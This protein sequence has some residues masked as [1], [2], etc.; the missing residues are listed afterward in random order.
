MLG[1]YLMPNQSQFVA[2][3]AIY[4]IYDRQ[5]LAEQ[6][7]WSRKYQ[8]KA[9]GKKAERWKLA[10]SGGMFGFVIENGIQPVDMQ[11]WKDGK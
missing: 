8:G 7:V 3:Y 2:P 1:Q 4:R 9:I 11:V 5:E 10:S 6:V